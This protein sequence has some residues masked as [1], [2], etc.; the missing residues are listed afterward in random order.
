[1]GRWTQ[2]DEDDYRLPEGM[3]RVGY[4]SDTSTYYFRD[5]SDGTLWAGAPGVEYGEM[6]QVSSAP[7]ALSDEHSDDDGDI[8]AA[9]S[10][11]G[12]GYQPLATDAV[13]SRPHDPLL[14]ER[15][16]AYRTLFPFIMIV[17][18]VLLL[19]IRLMMPTHHVEDPVISMCKDYSRAYR[20]KAG[21]TCWDIATSRGF[22]VE[23]L[24][25]ANP[26]LE[27][28]RLTPTQ[29]VCLPEPKPT[30]SKTKAS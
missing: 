29:L 19:V 3:K 12:D 2:Y 30:S 5:T 23:D 21:D 20:V 15:L 27:C 18:V 6:H 28:S 11:R 4:D 7:I 26:G 17:I 13:G 14:R 25:D 9:A 22:K 16:G 1:M 8:E 10:D 24:L